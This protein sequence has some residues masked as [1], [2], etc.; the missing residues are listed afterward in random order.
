[1]APP[2]NTIALGGN[3]STRKFWADKYIQSVT[4]RWPTSLR[5]RIHILALFCSRNIKCSIYSLWSAILVCFLCM[6]PRWQCPWFWP[7]GGGV[8]SG[9]C[10]GEVKIS[11]LPR[12][13]TREQC[14]VLTQVPRS[15]ASHPL[16]STFRSST[17]W[18]THFSLADD[19]KWNMFLTHSEPAG[20][21]IDLFF[22]LKPM[23]F[24]G[25]HTTQG[26]D[27]WDSMCS[28]HF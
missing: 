22:T 18:L 19:V 14:F 15:L 16:F 1:M 25:C 13:F 10:R 11:L 23:L 4:S 27:L 26:C 6:L 20:V 28:A 12:G 8:P 2:P 5:F 24:P 7:G 3:A 21:L 17:R 9:Y